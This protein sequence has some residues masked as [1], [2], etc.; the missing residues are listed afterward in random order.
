MTISVRQI[1]VWDVII[2]RKLVN[3]KIFIHRKSAFQGFKSFFF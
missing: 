3:A 1:W 2:L